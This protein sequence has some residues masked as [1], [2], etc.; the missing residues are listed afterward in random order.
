MKKVDLIV[1]APHI[2]T[3]KGEG[4][5]YEEK[6]ALVVDGSKIIDIVDIDKLSDQYEAEEQLDMSH[7]ILLPG[8]IDAH[9]HTSCN[10]M[11]GLAQD[12]NNWMM[13][14]LQPF[15]NAAT[16]AE[17]DI[18]CPVAL[19]EAAKAGTTTMGDYEHGCILQ[20]YCQA[21]Y[22]RKRH[23][24]DSLCKKKSLQAWRTL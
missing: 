4:V 3:M 15:D 9:M 2:Y 12:T 20:F 19:I 13:Y 18:G 21:R 24:D 6:K 11:R 14:G 10:I 17:K 7:H 5:G 22:P 1:T 8:F 23:T 16:Q